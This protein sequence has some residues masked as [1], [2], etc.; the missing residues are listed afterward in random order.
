MFSLTSLKEG[1][2][3]KIEEETES[4]TFTE[5]MKTYSVKKLKK[6]FNVCILHQRR[7]DQ[8][9]ATGFSSRSLTA[10]PEMLSA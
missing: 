10:L 1:V 8:S 2:V 5:R 3:E 9:S 4:G 7:R 6:T